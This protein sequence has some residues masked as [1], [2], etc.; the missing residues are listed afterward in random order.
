MQ[1]NPVF[2]SGYHINHLQESE[3]NVNNPFKV[4]DP[5]Y[6]LETDLFCDSTALSQE[7]FARKIQLQYFDSLEDNE[8]EDW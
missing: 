6:I 7:D 4:D 1:S 8:D 5:K 2:D 3:L